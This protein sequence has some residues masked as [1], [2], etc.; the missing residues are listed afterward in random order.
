ME[1][2]LSPDD[3]TLDTTTAVGVGNRDVFYVLRL[4]GVDI[5]IADGS[6]TPTQS[7]YKPSLQDTYGYTPVKS[8]WE[9][10]F[11][12]KWQPVLERNGRGYLRGQEFSVRH[13]GSKIA[14]IMT[15]DQVSLRKHTDDHEGYALK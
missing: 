10:Y 9:I 2:G 5:W 11:P 6:R 1:Y 15:R 4:M 7:R 14:F 12:F 8:P 13:I 3:H